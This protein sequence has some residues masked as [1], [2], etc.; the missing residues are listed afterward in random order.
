MLTEGSTRNTLNVQLTAVGGGKALAL[1]RIVAAAMRAVFRKGTTMLASS[2]SAFRGPNRA[3]W[4]R[5][6]DVP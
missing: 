2:G 3:G 5:P 4:F 6:V 1:I